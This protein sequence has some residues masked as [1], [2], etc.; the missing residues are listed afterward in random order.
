MGERR[1]GTWAAFEYGQ[2]VARQNGKGSGIEARELAGLFLFEEKLIIH[3]A[4]ELKTSLEAFKR[5]R[6][7]IQNC[8]DLDRQV[9]RI[10]TTNGKESIETMD[11]SVI[12]FVA[13]SDKSGRGFSG[14]LIVIDEAMFTEAEAI[15][16]LLPTLAA[17]PNGTI[18]YT[19]SAPVASSVFWHNIRTRA[20]AQISEQRRSRLGWNSWETEP[21]DAD[22]QPVELDINDDHLTWLT[23][24]GIGHRISWDYIDAER[25]ALRPDLYARERLSVADPEVQSSISKLD[26]ELWDAMHDPDSEPIGELVLGIDVAPGHARAAISIAGRDY[27]N[28]TH[29]EVARFDESTHWV[30]S[31]VIRM[32]AKHSDIRHVVLNPRSPAG[33]MLG[34]LKIAFDK[35]K[36]PP[37]IHLVGSSDRGR[38]LSAFT[39]KTDAGKVVH[40][41][42]ADLDRAV[43]SARLRRLS[44]SLW[45]TRDYESDRIA[46]LVAA[47]YAFGYL[48]E[49]MP[50][51]PR[52]NP[53][54]MI[55]VI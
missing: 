27:E 51:T 18:W 16:A 14:D 21:L 9:K 42:Q 12:Q 4:H 28:S 49:N 45:F 25:E 8:P 44:D 35:M 41:G 55:M 50:E 26:V 39:Q 6:D 1:D 22:G 38:Y 23:N 43:R 11:G 20:H 32:V 17:R 54:E 48:E 15:A 13:R 33:G 5:L 7:L 40:L 24:P 53:A 2:L 34:A 30:V 37:E 29:L 10:S 47:V 46:S 31:E 52:M 36:N 19:G 3:T